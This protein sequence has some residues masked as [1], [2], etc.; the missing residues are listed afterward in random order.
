[1]ITLVEDNPPV[2][3]TLPQED[4]RHEIASLR[5]QVAIEL[6]GVQKY[7]SGINIQL[8]DIDEEY[9]PNLKTIRNRMQTFDRMANDPG[10]R[11]QLRAIQMTALSGIQAKA[12]GGSARC[13]KL[14]ENNLLRKGPRKFWMATS[15]LDFLYEA[16]G[17]LVHGFAPFGVSWASPVDGLQLIAKLTWLHPRSFDEDGWVMDENDNLLAVRRSYTTGDGQTRAREEIDAADLFMLIWDRRGPNWEGN[18][19]IRPMYKPW[20]L[21]EMAEKIDI[22]DLQ[23]RGVGIPMATLSAAGGQKE[24]EFLTE[25]LKHARGSNK[26]R[27]FILLQQGEEVKY[28]TSEGTVKDAQPTLA[29]HQMGKAKSAGTEY[30]EQGNTAT[31]SRA[32]ASAL[33]SGFFINVNGIMQVIVDQINYG[34]GPMQGIAER[35]CLRNY[36]DDEPSTV[37]FTKLSPTEQMDN[38]PIIQDAVAKGLIPPMYSIA[39]EMS[40]RL[41]WPELDKAEWDEAMKAKQSV[42]LGPGSPARG[43]PGRPDGAGD[44]PD[45][46]DDTEGRRLMMQDPAEKKNSRWRAETPEESRILALAQIDSGLTSLEAAYA[47]TLH[48]WQD[49]TIQRIAAK[50]RV[51]GASVLQSGLPVYGSI[52][53]LRNALLTIRVRIA[54]FGRGQVTEEIKRQS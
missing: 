54:N 53:E 48:R 8:G 23:N 51:E 2:K 3:R 28:L 29:Y 44:D 38:I 41:G 20:M 27:A 47:E 11:A 49:S 21:G 30:F 26:E 17:C 13:R 9:V 19:F 14:L 15:W 50:V 52:P 33:A 36:P 32:G 5:A 25:I 46:R 42:T 43:G 45:G 37:E 10:V 1:M 31:G 7:A 40:K 18:A 34:P 35:L 22:I 4:L 16:M 12:V 39:N 24:K 6:S